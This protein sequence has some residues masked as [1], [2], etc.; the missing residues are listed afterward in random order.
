LDKTLRELLKQLPEDEI[1]A[2][3]YPRRNWVLFKAGDEIYVYNYSNSGQMT[4]KTF[5]GGNEV[6]VR[7]PPSW[8]LFVGRLAQQKAFFIRES[9]DMITGGVTGQIN[10][11]D[12]GTFGELGEAVSFVYESAW[13]GFDSK[14]QK[15][16]KRKHGKFIRPVFEAPDGVALR[17]SVVAPYSRDSTDSVT[18]SAA[19]SESVIG[20]AEIGEW[21][22]GGN[23]VTFDKY[24]M[25]WHGEAA[26]FR[27]EGETADG[28]LT[29]SA[30]T[31]YYAQFGSR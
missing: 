9:G 18:V 5:I 1:Q 8:H 7:V 2:I 31:V 17:I 25:R 27:F 22:I 3:H 14:N 4:Q 21:I 24:P 16:V 13:H 20:S 6:N 29:L 26:K 28:P 30:Y 11:F 12:Q 15:S 19:T 10:V 23:D